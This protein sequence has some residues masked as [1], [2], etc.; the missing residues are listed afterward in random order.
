MSHQRHIHHQPQRPGS[1]PVQS[2]E[3]VTIQKDQQMHFTSVGAKRA[4]FT[5]TLPYPLVLHIHTDPN[6]HS[7]RDRS[8]SFNVGAG[9]S[10]QFLGTG[11]G[12]KGHFEEGNSFHKVAVQSSGSIK[13]HLHQFQHLEGVDLPSSQCSIFV[14]DT[15]GVQI[16]DHVLVH[17]NNRYFVVQN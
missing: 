14:Y 12:L 4:N 6:S 7:T 9:L 5:N 3:L 1:A 17:E 11:G 15:R 13:C 2:Y 10:A 8:N 16:S